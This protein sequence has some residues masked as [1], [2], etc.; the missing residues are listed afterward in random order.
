MYRF[1]DLRVA[2]VAL[3]ALLAAIVSSA[4]ADTL[5]NNLENVTSGAELATPTRRLTASFGAGP[6]AFSLGSDTLLLPNPFC[7]RAPLDLHADGN[8]EPGARIATLDSPASYS[9]TP[10]ATVF[11]AS[12]V[13]LSANT[14][15]WIVLRPLSGAFEWAWTADNSG[16]GVG[17]Q[18][19]WGV[20][21]DGGAAWWSFDNYATQ[22]S[23]TDETP[24]TPGDVN[25]DGNVD[26][27]D[28]DAFLLALFDPAGY[29]STY[30]ACSLAS[31]DINSDGNVDFFDIDPFVLC[32][33]ATCP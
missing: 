1:H 24:F 8:F 12:G 9:T 30:P 17:F 33:F 10:A 13:T 28:I 20:S 3:L 15:Y 4:A 27:F 2:R 18:H 26:F 31:A 25:C 6:A 11:N 14:T 19:V 29:A 16:A 5:S 32:L 23:V 7:A 22:F 21:D